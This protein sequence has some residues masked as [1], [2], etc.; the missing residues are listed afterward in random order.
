MAPSKNDPMDLLA[1]DYP[2]EPLPAGLELV[3]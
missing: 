2:P 3:D 1:V